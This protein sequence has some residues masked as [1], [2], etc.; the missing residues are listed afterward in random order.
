M[1]ILIFAFLFILFAPL[2]T[3]AQWVFEKELDPITDEVKVVTV[4]TG[5]EL[6]KSLDTDAMGKL[7]IWCRQT[8]ENLRGSRA[9]IYHTL[10]SETYGGEH[11]RSITARVDKYEPIEFSTSKISAVGAHDGYVQI[12]SGETFDQTRELV[13]QIRKGE[14]IVIRTRSEF[15]TEITFR[16]P[17]QGID[18]A[19]PKL[20]EF[21]GLPA[22]YPDDED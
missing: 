10:F 20:F 16:F 7:V 2:T 11:M 8:D 13:S 6:F 22:S 21:C 5:D 1:K 14:S 19:L 18:D 15:D 12:A 3:S 4:N 9:A 17:L